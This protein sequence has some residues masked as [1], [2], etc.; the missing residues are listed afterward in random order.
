[1]GFVFLNKERLAKMRKSEKRLRR[2]LIEVD[3]KIDDKIRVCDTQHEAHKAH[4]RR[5][6]DAMNGLT[7]AVKELTE[8]LRGIKKKEEIDDI[9]INRTK[10]NYTALDVITETAKQVSVIVGASTVL[11]GAGYG[12]LHY[13]GVL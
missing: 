10:N 8:E 6:D 1:M 12:I 11:G 13:I 7:S 4:D 3:T 5:H 2:R 9:T